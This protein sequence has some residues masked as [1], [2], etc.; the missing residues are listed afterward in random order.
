M[1]VQSKVFEKNMYKRVIDFIETYKILVKCQLG[2]RNFHST[3]MALMTLI[4]KLITTLEN[5]EQVV[6]KAFDTVH[7]EILLKN[8]YHYC[9]RGTASKWFHSY[10]SHWHQYVTCGVSQGSILGSMLFLMYIND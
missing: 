2:F 1:C 8:V 3:Y 6:S 4:D 9:V 10:L 7:H 5:G